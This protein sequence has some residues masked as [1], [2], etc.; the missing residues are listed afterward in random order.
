M[1]VNKLKLKN[2]VQLKKA[3]LQER[4]KGK[5]IVLT[6]GSWDMLH[7]GHMRYLQAA[8]NE[9]DILV[10]GIDSDKKIKKRK[11]DDRPI[12]SEK[13]RV[14]MI[15]HLGCTDYIFIKKDT[16]KNNML[17][18]LVGPDV[19]ILSET[20]KHKSSKKS[21]VTQ[22]SKKIK[23]LPAQAETSTSARIRLLHISGKKDLINTLAKE[24]PEFIHKFLDHK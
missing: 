2:K 18:E 4:K 11:G 13:E 8:K 19:L 15:T 9:G 7:V 14:E 21:E 20:T 17:I 3:I 23:I 5:S 10:V 6:S 12:V 16:D 24:I 1:Q 22:H